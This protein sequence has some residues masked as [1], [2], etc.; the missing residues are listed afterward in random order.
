VYD[1]PIHGN[2][3]SGI[4]TGVPQ[5]R[6]GSFE[7]LQLTSRWF[8]SIPEPFGPGYSV[9]FDKTIDTGNWKEI[10]LWVHVFINNYAQTPLTAGASLIVRFLHVFGGQLGGGGQFDYTQATISWKGF[11]SFIDGYVTAPIIGDKLRILCH[12]G[13]LPP[14]PYGLFVSYYLV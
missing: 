14:G 12:P 3:G 8:E 1:A 4:R 11:T 7:W 13:N 5:T 10:R 9:A 2:S 6:E